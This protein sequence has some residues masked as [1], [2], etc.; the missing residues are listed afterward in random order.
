MRKTRHVSHGHPKMLAIPLHIQYLHTIFFSLT[1]GEMPKDPERDLVKVWA[2]LCAQKPLRDLGFPNKGPSNISGSLCFITSR[3]A[4]FEAHDGM[5]S[6]LVRESIS[7]CHRKPGWYQKLKNGNTK[8]VPNIS[9]GLLVNRVKQ[10]H[11]CKTLSPKLQT[12]TLLSQ[13]T[14]NI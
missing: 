6:W 10:K 1:F 12:V 11:L 3:Q 8:Q 9:E 13:T 5:E 7:G 2:Q 4:G 14:S